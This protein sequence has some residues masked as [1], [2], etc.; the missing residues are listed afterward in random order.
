M[1]KRKKNNTS[2]FNNNIV[3]KKF[4]KNEITIPEEEL[5]MNDSPLTFHKVDPSVL[6]SGKII[7]SN[8]KLKEY[9]TDL[10][11]LAKTNAPFLSK[12]QEV[13]EVV[14][15]ESIQEEMKR[16]STKLMNSLQKEGYHRAMAVNDRGKIIE[17]ANLK[18]QNY[19]PA[20]LKALAM[21]TLTV[22]VS[23]EHLQEI[24]KELEKIQRS[25]NRLISMRKNEYY[26]N[27]KGSYEYL[28]RAYTFYINDEIT[29]RVMAQLESI[30]RENISAIYSILKD[31]DDITAQVL[32]LKKKVWMWKTN[33]QVN[34]LK[35]IITEYNDYENLLNLYFSNVKGC[36]KIMELYGDSQVIINHSIASANDLNKSFESNKKQFLVELYSYSTDFKTRFTTNNYLVEKQKSIKKEIEK[37]DS[38]SNNYIKRSLPEPPEKIYLSVEDN[39]IISVFKV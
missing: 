29:D 10:L 22:V 34:N 21:N 13:F 2:A 20:Q 12:G 30:Y 37:V 36:L 3:Q 4:I 28:K 6:T 1:R 23:Q 24:R 7:E 39:E 35:K 19:N 8:N 18:V 33:E 17:H 32:I 38:K 25:L 16:G 9:S 5:I 27:A 14:F 15:S 11:K 31:L 26:G